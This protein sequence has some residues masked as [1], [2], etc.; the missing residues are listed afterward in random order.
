MTHLNQA[1]QLLS[2]HQARQSDGTVS[3][4]HPGLDVLVGKGL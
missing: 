3:G 1:A 4:F 2:H